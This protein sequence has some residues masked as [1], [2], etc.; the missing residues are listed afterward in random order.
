MKL[1]ATVCVLAAVLCES[2]AACEGPNFALLGVHQL[3]HVQQFCSR[4]GV[5]GP[6]KPWKATCDDVIAAERKLPQ[7][8]ENIGALVPL[9]NLHHGFRQYIGFE[10]EGQRF[11]FVNHVP[12][13]DQTPRRIAVTKVLDVCD[14]GEFVWSAEFAV[15]TTTFARFQVSGPDSFPPD[16]S[17][18]RLIQE[19]QT[20]K[21]IRQIKK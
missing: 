1:N 14:G 15:N 20:E 2:S 4:G 11:L 5:I 3:S 13:D 10:R 19:Q 18:L 12:E 17:L 9:Q 6:V 7:F 21:N 8:L 16:M